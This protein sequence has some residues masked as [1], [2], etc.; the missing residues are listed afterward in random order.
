MRTTA[1]GVGDQIASEAICP[2]LD[3]IV[4]GGLQSSLGEGT[5]EEEVAGSPPRGQ[6][7]DLVNKRVDEPE[8]LRP[9]SVSDLQCDRGRVAAILWPL[10][11]PICKTRGSR[12]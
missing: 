10:H 7:S 4:P 11:A 1:P 12:R 9:P 6:K 5:E 8:G 2:V 3:A